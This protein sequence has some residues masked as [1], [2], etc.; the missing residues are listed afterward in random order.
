MDHLSELLTGQ[1]VKQPLGQ[2]GRMRKYHQKF[3]YY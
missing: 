1:E 2:W 3:G